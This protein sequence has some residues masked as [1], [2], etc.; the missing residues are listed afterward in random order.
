MASIY[1]RSPKTFECEICLLSR[2][3]LSRI[4]MIPRESSDYSTQG[5]LGNQELTLSEVKGRFI[6]ICMGDFFPLRPVSGK[7]SQPSL[8]GARYIMSLMCQLTRHTC[9]RFLKH[10]S[11]APW[12]ISDFIACATITQISQRQTSSLD[13]R[14]TMLKLDRAILRTQWSS[15]SRTIMVGNISQLVTTFGTWASSMMSY[16]LINL[17]E[18]WKSLRG[19]SFAPSHEKYGVAYELPKD[20]KCTTRDWSSLVPGLRASTEM[21]TKILIPK[22]EA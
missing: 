10:I 22:C 20:W 8:G 4:P 13:L 21:Y 17:P 5:I 15:G 1:Y 2:S 16:R 9:M 6:F 12:A 7:Y 14:S 18:R 11:E 19:I 3:V